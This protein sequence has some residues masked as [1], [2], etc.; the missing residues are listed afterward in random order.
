M[1]AAVVVTAMPPTRTAWC[2]GHRGRQ[3]VHRSDEAGDERT[4]RVAVHLAWRA[5]LL[6]P[7]VRHDA[8]AIADAQRLFL[9]VG[10]EQ[11]GDAELGLDAPDL[12]AQRGAHLGVQ[13]R[14]WLVEQQHLRLD[15]QR[16][17]QRDA[18]LLA[19]RH[20]V[21]V[22]LGHRRQLHQF[23]HLADAAMCARPCRC[24]R[25]RKPVLDVALDGEVGEQAVALE[26]HAHVA[27]VR[28]QVG[29]VVA[30]RP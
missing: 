26:H 13:R 18:L 29:D 11:G 21:R 15:G 9:I 27:L 6:E 10:D 8:D 22:S 4:G 5:Q 30:R 17:S 7:T 14:Q 12:V 24:L 1:V 23:Q 28:R 20:L 19:A 16:A 2:A 25:V 3:L